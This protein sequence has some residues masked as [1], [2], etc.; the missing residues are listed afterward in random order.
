[1]ELQI[2]ESL[3]REL[4]LELL[5]QK[6]E[7]F[8]SLYLP[9]ELKGPD[10]RQNP[11][12]YK[13]VINSLA[14]QTDDRSWLD[15][16]RQLEQ[17][18]TFWRE[19]EKGMALFSTPEK[20]VVVKLPKAPL[21]RANIGSR[22]EIL[23]L[24]PFLTQEHSFFILKVN[25]NNMQLLLGSRFGEATEVPIEGDIYTSIEEYFES[26][27]MTQQFR[28]HNIPSSTTGKGHGSH[29]SLLH[30]HGDVTDDQKMLIRRFFD[31]YHKGIVTL[32]HA[33]QLPVV[34]VGVEYLLPIFQESLDAVNP[35]QRIS[36]QPDS[37]SPEELQKE[38]W[39]V[40]A[41]EFEQEENKERELYQELEG[42]NRTTPFITDIIPLAVEGRIQTLFIRKG[43]EAWGRYDA[44][45]NEV[46]LH[47]ERQPNSE[48]LW[49]RA[50]QEAFLTDAKVFIIENEDTLLKSEAGAALLRY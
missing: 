3:S 11:I 33:N 43:A 12:R 7:A 30:G 22:F 41:P 45:K 8:L 34:L 36:Q 27:E 18:I 48:R 5:H 46:R 2:V 31:Q 47:T 4:L 23:P 6:G 14:E 38:A 42:S 16:L 39:K 17:D 10:T 13:N 49:E 35:V 24:L 9:L 21:E 29:D 20:V 25:L 37:L 1:M 44:E 15:A 26:L 32:L 50:A 28:S 19:Q 40:L